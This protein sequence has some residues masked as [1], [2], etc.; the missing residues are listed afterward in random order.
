MTDAL[1]VIRHVERP[2][3][4]LPGGATYQ[5]IIGDDTGEGLPIRTGIQTS[6]PGYA[7]PLHSHPYAEILTVVEG[8]GEAWLDGEDGVVP[9]EPGVTVTVPPH[10]VHAF[11]VVGD[12][13]LVTFGI[14]TFG[15]RIVNYVSPPG[16]PS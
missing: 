10:R 8:R 4:T 2:S 5:P 6:Q 12:R 1:T 15:K 13:P 14:H 16:S 3:V 7:T 11:R 9:L